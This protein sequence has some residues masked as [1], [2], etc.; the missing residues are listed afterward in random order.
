MSLRSWKSK[1]VLGTDSNQTANKI[2]QVCTS[3]GRQY[4]KSKY[5]YIKKCR[6]L[7]LS[8]CAGRST[9]AFKLTGCFIIYHGHQ[10]DENRFSSV[11]FIFVICY[12]QDAISSVM[13]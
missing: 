13:G 9:L 3:T 8:E 7:V 11:H 2:T 12:N 10:V 6:S 5:M 4:W 1:Y